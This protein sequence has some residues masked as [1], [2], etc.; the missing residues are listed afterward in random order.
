MAHMSRPQRWRTLAVGAAAMLVLAPA[1]ATQPA[2]RYQPPTVPLPPSAERAFRAMSRRI[3]PLAA[4][5]TVRYLDQFWRIAGNPG[6][7][8]SIDHVR[9]RL[10]AAGF[11]DKPE[12]DRPFL[13]VEEGTDPRLG[14][15]GWN[16]GGR[17]RWRSTCCRVSGIACRSVSTPSRHPKVA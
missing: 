1:P 8:S 13:R 4:M 11:V 6:F 5:E 14:L 9:T 3:D 17:R 16:P 15:P 7:N 10:L 12:K 2:E